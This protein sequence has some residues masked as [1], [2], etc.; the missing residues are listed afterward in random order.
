VTT[1]NIGAIFMVQNVSS[2]VRTR[3]FD[4]KNYFVR[5]N[6][7]DGIIKIEFVKSENNHSNILTKNVKQETYKRNVKNFLE[8]YLEEFS[9]HFGL[10]RVLEIS[11]TFSFSCFYI[12]LGLCFKDIYFVL[13]ANHSK[14]YD[15]V[16][17][18]D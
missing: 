16:L 2:G 18:L 5:E 8:N 7:E 13:K 6:L 9:E 15:E 1:D 4:T 3:H 17:S 14:R 11:L 12:C 10:G